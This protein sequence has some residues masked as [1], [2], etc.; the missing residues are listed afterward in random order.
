MGNYTIEENTAW[1]WRYT[2]GK[3]DNA[4][5]SPADPEGEITCTNKKALDFWLNGFSV[6]IRNI[7][8]KKD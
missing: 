8:G 5:L 6:V 1:S 4:A 3:C 7:F 2:A